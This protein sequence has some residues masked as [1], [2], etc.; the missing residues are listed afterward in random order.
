M[1]NREVAIEFVK[2]FCSGD[3]G[4]LGQLLADEFHLSG[5]L[6]EFASKQEY[7]DSLVRDGLERA[8][9]QILSVTESADTVSMG[10]WSS[11][12]A[13]SSRVSSVSAMPESRSL[14]SAWSS[15]V[16]FTTDLLHNGD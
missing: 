14:R 5:P 1:S 3:V 15:S 13:S 7:L 6:F 12:W 11:L 8:S 2:R 10:A 9:Y 4:G 16:G